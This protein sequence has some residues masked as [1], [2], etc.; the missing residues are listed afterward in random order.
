M[1]KK[2]SKWRK[3]LQRTFELI[4]N[5]LNMRGQNIDYR[6]YKIAFTR[7]LPQNQIEI[8]QMVAQLNGIV[9]QE[10]LLGQIPFVEK[11]QE[12]LKRVQD[13]K[14]AAFDTMQFPLQDSIPTDDEE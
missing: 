9:S 13:E 11:P 5:V 6:N 2:E 8:S 12:E 14:Q 3:S 7:A 10:T 1:N 4:C